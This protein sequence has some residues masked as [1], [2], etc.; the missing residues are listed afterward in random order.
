LSPARI[1]V[2]P[3][4]DQHF[5]PAESSL[6]GMVGASRT[7]ERRIMVRLGLLVAAL[8]ALIVPA[9]ALSAGTPGLQ[10]VTGVVAP[11]LGVEIDD[12]GVA[13]AGARDG[14][15]VTAERRG[16]QLVITIVP[17]A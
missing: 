8:A 3:E 13:V 14:T 15:T 12:H 1:P 7:W 16:D 11:M 9:A 4:K 10:L 5:S 2:A 6:V 17:A